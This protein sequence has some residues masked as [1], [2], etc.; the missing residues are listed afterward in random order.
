MRSRLVSP[1]IRLV[2]C[3]PRVYSTVT[4]PAH[5]TTSRLAHVALGRRRRPPRPAPSALVHP[6]HVIHERRDV[7]ETF[8]APRTRLPT[9][10]R[11]RHPRARRR[12]VHLVRRLRVRD[13]RGDVREALAAHVA[14]LPR[15]GR[16]RPPLWS[17]PL[18]SSCRGVA[19]ASARRGRPRGD[20]TRRGGGEG[21]GRGRP[22]T[23][24][25]LAFFAGVLVREPVRHANLRAAM[26]ASV[27]VHRGE[28]LLAS[29]RP[30]ALR[31]ARVLIRIARSGRVSLEGDVDALAGDV[32]DAAAAQRTHDARRILR[33]IGGTGVNVRSGRQ[34]F[35]VTSDAST[36]LRDV[37][38][39]VVVPVVQ[40]EGPRA[41]LAHKGQK[42]QLAAS[43]E[44]TI[45]AERR[46]LHR[47]API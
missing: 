42:V 14:H 4:A 35:V 7:V 16:R 1:A 45:L 43:G 28:F 41:S 6:L 24:R 29:R 23:V 26:A 20:G 38:A 15:G 12:P 40:A 46:Y 30:A 13:E 47:A 39:S 21:R 10:A 19:D 11:P 31:P 37:A 8:A 27:R 3:H 32:L 33:V 9:P 2:L 22:P 5:A 36:H 44:R 34:R 25:A 18:W 17:S